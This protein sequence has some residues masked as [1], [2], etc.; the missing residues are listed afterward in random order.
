MPSHK[1]ELDRIL[2]STYLDG[3]EAKSLADI[4]S[5]RTEC[6]EAE[7]ALSYLRRLIQGRLDIVHAYL[8][9]PGSDDSPDL[10]ALVEDLPAI[11]SAGPGRPA[12]PGHLPLLLSPDT[13]E[14]DLTAELDAVLGADEIGTL[15]ELDIDQLNSIAGQLEAIESRVSVDRR[16]LH[17]R[18]DS[19]Q[20][21]LVDRHKT[22]RASVDGLLS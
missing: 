2:T 10:A 16:A 4:R 5:M 1:D 8:E 13:E 7:V 3:I 15:A 21:E 19:L 20:A 11:L 18:I 6:Q 22:G 12:G 17:E 9:H 14:S